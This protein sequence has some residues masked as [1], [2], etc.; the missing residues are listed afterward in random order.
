MSR[1]IFLD[2]DREFSSMEGP[3]GNEPFEFP[4]N[5]LMDSALHPLASLVATGRGEGRALVRRLNLRAYGTNHC[6][7]RQL[8]PRKCSLHG[9]STWRGENFGQ[10][11]Y[12]AGIC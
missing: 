4:G 12:A 10:A 1:V 11:I 6:N 2:G 3:S 5:H 7:L 8:E 9:R